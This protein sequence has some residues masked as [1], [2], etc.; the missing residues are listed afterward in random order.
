MEKEKANSSSKKEK[1]YD[2]CGQQLTKSE[3]AEIF[4]ISAAAFV[5]R[6]NKGEAPMEAVKFLL[7]L[8]GHEAS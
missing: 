2:I 8:R 4:G 3:V 7:G 5:R 6:V 1:T